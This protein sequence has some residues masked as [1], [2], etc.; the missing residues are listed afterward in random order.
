MRVL[1]IDPGTVV[2]GYGVVEGGTTASLIECG[3]LKAPSRL[4]VERRLCS[5]FDGICSVIDASKPDEVAIE[6]PFAGVNVR[7]AFMV[8][9]AQ[10]LAILAASRRDIPI[11]YYS[12][13]EVKRSVSGYG[14]GDKEQVRTMVMLQLGV[15]NLAHELDATDALAVALCHLQSRHAEL[16]L[17]SGPR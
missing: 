15:K 12:P 16:R 10:A 1:G 6:E 8:G 11:S 2:L 14:R 5:L 7:S 17:T 9:R 4:P 13:A 3:V